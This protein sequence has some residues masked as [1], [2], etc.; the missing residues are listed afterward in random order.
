MTLIKTQPVYLTIIVIDLGWLRAEVMRFYFI[1]WAVF[2]GKEV[3]IKPECVVTIARPKDEKSLR[4]TGFGAAV[5]EE[6]RKDP[7]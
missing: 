4:E 7:S 6:R 1:L 5:S 2:A 3:G